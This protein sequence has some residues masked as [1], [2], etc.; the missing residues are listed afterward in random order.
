MTAYGFDVK[1]TESDCVAAL[2][3]LY[4]RLTAPA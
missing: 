1:M 4:Q 2:F 3:R